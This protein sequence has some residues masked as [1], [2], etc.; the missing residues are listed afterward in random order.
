[1]ELADSR[2]T[3]QQ[4]MLVSETVNVLSLV[5]SSRMALCKHGSFIAN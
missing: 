4:S 2:S 1:M 5:F 3:L